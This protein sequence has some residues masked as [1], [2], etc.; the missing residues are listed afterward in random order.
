MKKER[1]MK[2]DKVN[3][4]LSDNKIVSAQAPVIISA[5]RATDIPAFYSKWFIHRLK[6]NYLKWI[7][8]FNNKPLY[9]SFENTRLI[10]FWSK[11][12]KPM[13][14]Y[15]DFL[16]KRNI[17]YYFQFTLNDYEKEK[18]EA[19]VPSLEQRIETFKILSKK[20]GKKRVIW[21]FDPLI[22]TDKIDIEE[23]LKRIKTI[24]NE[25]KDY[26]NKLVI[27]F[28]DI[29]IYKKVSRNL[30]HENINYKEWSID[31]MKE[32]AK[33]IQDITKDWNIQIVTCSEK[34][35]LENYGIIHNKCIDDDLIIELFNNDKKLMDFLGVEIKERDLFTPQRQIIKTKKLKD[36][37]QR[38]ACGC[39]ISKDIGQYNTCPYGCVYCYANASKEIAKRN[40]QM[41]LK[42][43]YSETI[44]GD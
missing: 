34:I 22:L 32:F 43:P 14:K 28:V 37:G 10:V 26:T 21:R 3:I 40:F 6:E 5:S 30:K 11:N 31:L 39:I 7:N 29:S 25:L 42:N 38:E 24:G 2:W 36:K 1:K 8:P 15:L 9:I 17:N 23:L 27:S 44:K 41:H 18:F 19:K 33:G 12:P 16:N 4:K 20:L 13:I 35:N